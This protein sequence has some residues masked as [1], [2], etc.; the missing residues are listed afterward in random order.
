M[1]YAFVALDSAAERVAG[2]IDSQTAAQALVELKNRELTVLELRVAEALEKTEDP[3]HRRKLKGANG[4]FRSFFTQKPKATKQ[5]FLEGFVSQMALFTRGGVH[6]AKAIRI[7][8][9][10]EGDTEKQALLSELE[11]KIRSGISLSESFERLGFEDS[12]FLGMVRGGELSGDMLGAFERIDQHLVRRRVMRSKLVSSLIYPSILAFIAILSVVL[13]FGFVLPQFEDIFKGMGDKLPFLTVSAMAI[14][15]AMRANFLEIVIVLCLFV[16]FAPRF[17]NVNNWKEVL[18]KFA[19]RIPIIRSAINQYNCAIFLSALGSLLKSG[20]SLPR[21]FETSL[22]SISD[23]ELRTTLGSITKE[24]RE[25]KIFSSCLAGTNAFDSVTIGLIRVGEE[26]GRLQSACDQM[27]ETLSLRFDAKIS[28]V[29]QLIE[30][31]MILF[32]GIIVGVIIIAILLGILS[33]NE[34]AV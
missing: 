1:N 30:P 9:E 14:S 22:L 6:L 23:S 29:L 17:F 28:R 7:L 16:A 19:R 24:L 25:G 15:S 34:F 2:F 20:L 26:T 31:L 3:R 21:A 8:C 12:F 4:S 18:A 10:A 33:I 11:K 5:A 27:A 32:L 13:M